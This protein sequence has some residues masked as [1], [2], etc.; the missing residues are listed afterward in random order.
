VPGQ[1]RPTTEND[2]IRSMGGNDTVHGLADDDA[3]D[4]GTGND[5]LL[6]GAGTDRL[7]GGPGNDVLVITGTG[8]VFDVLVGGTGTDTVLVAGTGTVA[9]AGFNAATASVEVWAGN[10][11]AVLGTTAA[12]TFDFSGLASISGMAY[13]DAS[14]GNDLLVG[15]R[16]AD[17]LRGGAGN[18]GLVGGV[19]NDRLTGGSGNDIFA[20]VKDHG[21]D[22]IT[23]FTAGSSIADRIQLDDQMYADFA[24]VRA[25]S[26]QVG[27]DVVIAHDSFD[28]ITLS[29][30]DLATLNQNDF[31][32]V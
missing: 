10:G 24:S 25:A 20:F 1:P 4:G 27:N 19:G 17:D 6:G 12:N 23:D 28:S 11:A 5:A 29:N 18:D 26:Q 16:F 2:V 8:D 15:S 22:T 21:H 3:I 32:F 7:D 13:V 30:V 9:L 14:G 31:V